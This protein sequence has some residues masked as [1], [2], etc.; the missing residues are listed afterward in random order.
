MESHHLD[1]VCPEL[2]FEIVSQYN[3]PLRRQLSEALHILDTGS[4]NRR[5]EFNEKVICRLESKQ[6]EWELENRYNTEMLARKDFNEKIQSFIC[7][8]S[9]ISNYCD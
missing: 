3:D 4:L 8:M 5:M 2:K 1:T 7:V 6:T 9:S